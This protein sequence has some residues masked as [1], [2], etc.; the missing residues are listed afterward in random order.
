M[1]L[2]KVEIP[3]SFYLAVKNVGLLLPTINN[4]GIIFA[5]VDKCLLLLTSTHVEGTVNEETGKPHII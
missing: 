5:K 2:C 1:N 4:A 3:V